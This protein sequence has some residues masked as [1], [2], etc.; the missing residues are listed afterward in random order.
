MES[1]GQAQA[2]LPMS[3][4][5]PLV[6]SSAGLAALPL[7][8]DLHQADR[9][10]LHAGLPA[11]GV[12]PAL[13]LPSQVSTV[14]PWVAQVTGEHVERAPHAA[15]RDLAPLGRSP[16][17]GSETTRR[18]DRGR[19]PV[20]SGPCAGLSISGWDPGCH[21]TVPYPAMETAG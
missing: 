5:A 9:H 21:V 2:K 11:L 6:V 14:S 13:R 15:L 18:G 7:A 12:G 4:W 19:P 10:H 1:A 17:S 20:E 8:V 16:P 3:G